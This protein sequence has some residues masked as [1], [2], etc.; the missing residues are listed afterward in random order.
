MVYYSDLPAGR[1]PKDE[2]W[3]LFLMSKSRFLMSR[4][5][6]EGESSV[7]GVKTQFDA[8]LQSE[9]FLEEGSG[10]LWGVESYQLTFGYI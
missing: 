10:W 5:G 1:E 2:K 8:I 7:Y 6:S 4:E 3:E 9:D